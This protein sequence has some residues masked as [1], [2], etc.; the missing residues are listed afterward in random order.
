MAVMIHH[1]THPYDVV[2]VFTPLEGNPLP[3][4]PDAS[5]LGGSTMQRIAKEVNLN[6][7]ASYVTAR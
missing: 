2:H 1:A 5:L 6:I 4:F 3:V 7:G